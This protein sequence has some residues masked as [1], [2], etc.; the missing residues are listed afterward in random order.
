VKKVSILAVL[1]VAGFGSAAIAQQS[2]NADAQRSQANQQQQAASE[3][4]DEEE[5]EDPMQKVVCKSEPVLGSR[6]RVI[7]TCMTRAEWNYTEER[8][9]RE[10]DN[11]SRR[12]NTVQPS[13]GS[14]GGAPF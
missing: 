1:A 10:M 2:D 4:G 8:A 12:Q 7:R 13:S 3:D 14:G 5:E 9:R 6:T 11:L